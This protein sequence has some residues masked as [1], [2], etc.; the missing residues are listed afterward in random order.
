MTCR[1]VLALLDRYVDGELT[2]DTG[3]EIRSHLASCPS[4]RAEE[5][6]TASLKEL[7][8]QY[9]SSNPGEE[10]FNEV[11]S[12]VLAR[13]HDEQPAE[14]R[15]PDYRTIRREQKR[16]LLRALISAAVSVTVLVAALILGA[17][18]QRQAPQL[19]RSEQPVYLASALADITDYRQEP[20]ITSDERL[21]L[22]RCVTL[23]GPP[24]ALGRMFGLNDLMAVK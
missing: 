22:A 6:A 15:R 7:L 9:Q 4:C 11:P 20:I 23:L 21:N 10:Y 18:Q 12:L 16:S 1:T 24:G 8:G 2:G 5:S 14:I 17:A 19:V 3:R 13:T